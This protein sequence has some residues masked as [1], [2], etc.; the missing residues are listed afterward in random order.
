MS[1]T[2][3]PCSERHERGE[4]TDWPSQFER[5]RLARPR[6]NLYPWLLQQ[7]LGKPAA[8]SRHCGYG[9]FK[10]CRRDLPRIAW[11]SRTKPLGCGRPWPYKRKR[12]RRRSGVY[13]HLSHPAC[14]HRGLPCSGA[15]RVGGGPRP[16]TA[17]AG[18]HWQ[19]GALIPCQYFNFRWSLEMANIQIFDPALCCSTGVCGVDIDQALVSFAAD[20]DWAKQNGVQ[21]ERF[22]LA[23]QQGR[24]GQDD[25][26]SSDF[27]G[28]CTARLPCASDD[29]RPCRTSGRDAGEVHLKTTAGV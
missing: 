12:R 14:T 21:I 20:V 23:R 10:R 7:I 11:A 1:R 25:A 15:G 2:H 9:L 26:G 24:R 22:N 8:Y 16:T 29:I 6:G 4:P 17:R 5:D 27:G 3:S 19:V 18:P 28:A 13:G